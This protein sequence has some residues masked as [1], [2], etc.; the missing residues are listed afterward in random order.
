MLSNSK[1][2]KK[3]RFESSGIDIPVD[4]TASRA[5]AT[6]AFPL[7]VFS[8]VGARCRMP[9]IVHLLVEGKNSLRSTRRLFEKEN[10]FS[11]KA[12]GM[13][14]YSRKNTDT[15]LIE[16]V[17]WVKSVGTF[18]AESACASG[19]LA[20][21]YL[22]WSR[23]NISRVNI[24]QPSASMFS[25]HITKQTIALTGPIGLIEARTLYLK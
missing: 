4:V 6:V 1:R 25:I 24:I 23:E 7:A 19:S 5:A 16:P 12:A 8:A 10:L 14:A 2:E 3:Y 21:A 11:R 9:G 15:F 13:I 17:V 22:F 20:L 18:Y